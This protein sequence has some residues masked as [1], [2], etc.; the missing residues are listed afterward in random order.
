MGA[1]VDRSTV[2]LETVKLYAKV[3]SSDEDA[4]LQLLLD[5]A[6]EDADAYMGNAFQNADGEDLPIPNW[7]ERWL[8][9]QVSRDYEHRPDGLQ[10]EQ[11]NQL[12]FVNWSQRD[13]SG[14]TRGWKPRL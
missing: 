5:A 8:L 9:Q 2:T 6:K 3:E 7:V 11:V 10:I 12:G 1:V 14:L 4:L 13:Y